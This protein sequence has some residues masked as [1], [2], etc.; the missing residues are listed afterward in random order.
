GYKSVSSICCLRNCS[1]SA[2]DVKAN[3]IAAVPAGVRR[4]TRLSSTDEGR[5]QYVPYGSR[6]PNSF[7]LARYEA[8]PPDGQGV[9]G[10]ENLVY[11]LRKQ[12]L[13][14]PNAGR[15][16]VF[17]FQHIHGS[18]G[19]CSPVTDARRKCCFR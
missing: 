14:N 18:N 1:A 8:V 19:V 16:P 9:L 12:H 5:C 3:T 7:W 10:M 4:H 13:N 11:V 15:Y 2:C 17:I 6:L